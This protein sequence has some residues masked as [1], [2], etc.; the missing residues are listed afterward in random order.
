M[1]TDAATL[2]NSMKVP[3]K[4]KNKITLQPSYCIA[5]CLSKEYKN[6]DL[7]EHMHT[8]VYSSSINNSQIL[9]RA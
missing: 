8:N 3:Q 2:E 5:R 7:K 6:A 1:Q 4:I 9:Q